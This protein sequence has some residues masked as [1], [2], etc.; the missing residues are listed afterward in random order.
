M[1]STPSPPQPV[2][3]VVS[4]PPQPVAPVVPSPVEPLRVPGSIGTPT[5][6]SPVQ[7]AV[8]VPQLAPDVV[9]ERLPTPEPEPA[10]A[11]PANIEAPAPRSE[12]EPAATTARAPSTEASPS[13]PAATRG[14]LTL[15]PPMN[16]EES[17]MG[18]PAPAE[19][20]TSP[21][22]ASNPDMGSHTDEVDAGYSFPPIPVTAPSVPLAPSPPITESAS[23]VA[24]V[25]PTPV[26]QHISAPQTQIPAARTPSPLHNGRTQEAP[27]DVVTPTPPSTSVLG[28]TQ[29][30]TPNQSSAVDSTTSGTNGWAAVP[31]DPSTWTVDQVVAWAKGKGFDDAVQHK[32]FGKQT[33]LILPHT[34]TRLCRT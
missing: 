21:I 31:G 4:S 10:L 16:I 30:T 11:P 8:D 15:S 25:A 7:K 14:G 9:Q 24:V 22:M 1:Q 3:S 27:R 34:L 26:A 6:S 5:S 2:A 33:W 23:P 20:G 28:Q 17:P 32:F 12:V 29:F 13:A 18:T 19:F